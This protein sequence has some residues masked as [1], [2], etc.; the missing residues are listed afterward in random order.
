MP[1]AISTSIIF[2]TA[3][4]RAGLKAFL[5]DNDFSVVSEA[6]SLGIGV[7]RIVATAPDLVLIE[8]P[9][10]DS[11]E[12]ERLLGLKEKLGRARIV[13]LVD[14]LP[15]YA[16]QALFNAGVDGVLK[17]DIAPAALIGYINL[18]MLGET[19]VHRAVGGGGSGQAGAGGATGSPPF[20]DRISER[21]LMVIRHLTDGLSNKEIARE[22]GIVDGTI[23]IHVR[24]IQRKLQLKNRTQIAVWAVGN[25]V[26]GVEALPSEAA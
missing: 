18:V 5:Q 17:T 14:A 11:D 7:G 12:F 23:K 21:E 22:L 25:G 2:R 9:A 6:G 13:V 10:D 16:A 24:N 8:S 4:Q 15:T 19:V 20:I 3:L 26:M 1:N